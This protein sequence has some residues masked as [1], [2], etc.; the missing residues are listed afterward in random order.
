MKAF[1]NLFLCCVILV[2]G[3]IA[4]RNWTH[5]ETEP[6]SVELVSYDLSDS[7]LDKIHGI[8]DEKVDT[9]REEMRAIES[10]LSEKIAALQTQLTDCNTRTEA[11]VKAQQA[12]AKA[13]GGSS[14]T[15]SQ[16]KYAPASEVV[17][18]SGGS[19]GTVYQQKP[20]NSSPVIV[21]VVSSSSHWSYPGDITTH[22]QSAHGQN[23]SGMS[24]EQQLNLHD[25][26]HES[27]PV[28]SR[29]VTRSSVQTSNCPGGVCPVNTS[30]TT[31]SFVRP[32]LFGR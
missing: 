9:V 18:S 6:V 5:A 23:V 20:Y 1:A 4:L 10:Q 24:I 8:V 12:P 26:L 3:T 15:V 25:A 21:P 30:S 32:R 22:L 29:V 17:K 14:G 11:F 28:A 13:S 7:D 16:T 27:K 31:R 2:L 19:S